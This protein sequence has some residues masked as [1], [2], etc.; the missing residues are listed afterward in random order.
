MSLLVLTT[1]QE[2]RE[3]LE[4][5][6]KKKF[7]K[8]R[9]DC[10][11]RRLQFAE[12]SPDESKSQPA[13]VVPRL[14][15]RDRRTAKTA[16]RSPPLRSSMSTETA[17]AS[18]PRW[19][20]S[21]S[22]RDSSSSTPISTSAPTTCLSDSDSDVV[23]LKRKRPRRLLSDSGIYKHYNDNHNMTLTQCDC[24]TLQMMTI[25]KALVIALQKEPE[26]MMNVEL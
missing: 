3:K 24:Y 12:S 1:F 6:R 7:V 23:S 20:S 2:R 8:L 5:E 25:M 16:A 11:K 4:L 21:A 26:A 13:V 15:K 17:S 10:N 19:C 14:R 18:S 9:R 22:T